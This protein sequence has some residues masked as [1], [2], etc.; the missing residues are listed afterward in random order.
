MSRKASL[1]VSR[2]CLAIAFKALLSSGIA[3]A[4][5]SSVFSNFSITISFSEFDLNNYHGKPHL[6]A[7]IMCHIRTSSVAIVSASNS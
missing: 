5:R 1:S 4:C 6:M 7:A 3:R 2:S